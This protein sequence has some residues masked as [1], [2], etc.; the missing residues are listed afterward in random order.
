MKQLL[1]LCVIL[2]TWACSGAGTDLSPVETA[3]EKKTYYVKMD[4]MSLASSTPRKYFELELGI[5]KRIHEERIRQ[6]VTTAWYFYSVVPGDNTVSD[7]PYDYITVSVYED[8]NMVFD[9]LA[10][11]AIRIAYPGIDLD[12]LDI[13]NDEARAYVRSD[14]WE[15]VDVVS[16]YTDS[17]PASDYISVNY[18]D[19]RDHSG[20]HMELETGFWAGIHKERIHRGNLNSEAVFLL[21]NPE[22]T[23]RN[24]NYATIDYYDNLTQ[25][26]QPVDMALVK[27]AHPQLPE[28]EIQH[29]FDRT[30]EA[31]SVF[32]SELWRLVD[33]ID[34]PGK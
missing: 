1:I 33:Y 8:Y 31:R 22:G 20:E 2:F 3:E 12:E 16:P 28:N 14:L 24:Y 25:V 19:S 34:S 5:W 29:F 11:E 18:F 32:K 4:Y 23:Q 7:L 6:G 15:I 26:R 10:T 9:D 30:P 17:K 27:A 21:V 13:K